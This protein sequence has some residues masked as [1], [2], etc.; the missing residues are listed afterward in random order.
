MALVKQLAGQMHV[1]VDLVNRRPG[2]EVQL[3]FPVNC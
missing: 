3:K 1:V 2:I